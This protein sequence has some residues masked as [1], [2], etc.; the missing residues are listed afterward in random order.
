MLKQL[1][2]LFRHADLK[3]WNADVLA[4]LFHPT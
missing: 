2:L 4:G 1:S 3:A